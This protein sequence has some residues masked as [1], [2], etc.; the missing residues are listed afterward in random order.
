MDV[1]IEMISKYGFPCVA[2]SS[3]AYFVYFIWL[4]AINDI[5]PQITKADD[6]LI[7]L[8]DRLRMLDNDLIRLKEKVNTTLY[9]KRHRDSTPE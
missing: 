9:I 6:E 5:K 2:A 8:I 4:W 1:T 7:N 3:M